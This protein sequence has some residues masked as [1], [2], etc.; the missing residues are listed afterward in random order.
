MTIGGARRVIA[1]GFF[2]GVHTGHARL[3]RSAKAEAAQRRAVCSMLTFDVP[4]G[5]TTCG[6]ATP[7]INSLDDRKGLVRRLFGIEDVI[8]LHFDSELQHM[9]WEQFVDMLSCELRAE[10]LVAGYNFRFGRQGLGNAELLRR[11]CEELGMGCIII[12]EVSMDGAAVSST[13]IRALLAEGSIE[14][15]NRL[16]GHRH[17]ITGTV[18][19]GR[20]LGHA[21]GVPT[22]NLRL[23][24][25]V[26]APAH[27]V[28]FSLVHLSGR[29]GYVRA[30]TNI[31]VRPT[32]GEDG[33]VSVE[34]H[35]T[36]F[37]G[38]LYGQRVR[39]E[40]CR[41]SRPEMRFSSVDELRARILDDVEAAR[42]YFVNS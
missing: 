9:G 12:P 10:C 31:G 15:A 2:D 23:E 7:L 21:M 32:V 5:K 4:P 30:V 18:E 35:L 8:C 13:R 38:D 6:A 37:S 39:V 3:L 20:G 34:T 25:G 29:D 33:D 14:E 28:Y 26:L 11:R 24:S 19:R 22:I 40:L 16:L 41:F 1:L 36:D 17:V 27:G 42:E